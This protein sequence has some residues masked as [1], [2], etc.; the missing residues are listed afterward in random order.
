MVP[1]QGRD[2]VD[3][4]MKI[5]YFTT[6]SKEDCGIADYTDVLIDSIEQDTHKTGVKLRSLDI[7][8]YVKQTLKV[9]SGD[10]IHVQ[11]EY[12]IFG[13]KSITSWVVF[14]LLWLVSTFR[15]VP[16]VMTLHT[17]WGPDAISPPL[18][19]VKNAY[20]RLNNMMLKCVGDRFIFLT[21]EEMETFGAPGEKSV[22]M[23]HGVPTETQPLP[24]QEAKE[25]LGYVGEDLV[26]E[27]GYVR[28]EKGQKG[29]AEL[30]EYI[31]ATCVIAGGPQN[32]RGEE[33][34]KNISG[35][36]VTGVLNEEEFHLYLNAADLV[37]LPYEVV[38]Q[39]GI[40]NWCA[41]YGIPVVAN[42]IEGFE[43]LNEQYGYPLLFDTEKPR[44]AARIVEETLD[45]NYQETINKYRKGNGMNKV[46]ESHYKIYNDL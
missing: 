14:P 45:K 9:G 17:A 18:Y 3:C 20:I 4:I 39:S 42:R 12:G 32:P 8:D 26:I 22:V 43:K 46:A 6:S 44:E 16:V 11:H 29:F 37:V 35:V 21:E 24:Q 31:D 33:Y 41:A 23:P 2:Q 40:L 10:I 34:L 27:I 30:S 28:P 38:S 36:E 15:G 19:R 5:E 25:R 13:P 1:T 7:L